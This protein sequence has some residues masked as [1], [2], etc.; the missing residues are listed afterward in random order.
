[1]GRGVGSGVGAGVAE[2]TSA[3]RVC[4]A[5]QQD[6]HVQVLAPALVLA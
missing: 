3:V 4:V 2:R 1:V 6:T 5:T